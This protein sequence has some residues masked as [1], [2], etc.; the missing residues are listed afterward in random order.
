MSRAVPTRALAAVLVLASL[1]GCMAS[2]TFR[3]AAFVPG[4]RHYRVRY[5]PGEEDLRRVLPGDW[6]IVNYRTDGEGRPTEAFSAPRDLVRVALD[7]NGDRE[8]DV[9]GTTPRFDLHFQH[10]EDGATLS[11]I[12]VPIEPRLSR[13]S[14]AVFAHG[15]VN[16][17]FGEGFVEWDGDRARAYQTRIVEEQEATVGGAPAYL[18]TFEV[19]QVVPGEGPVFGRGETVTIVLVRPG[20][21]GWRGDSVASTGSGV[22]MLLIAMLGA[23]STRYELHRPDFESLLHRLDVRPDG[24]A[25]PPPTGGEEPQQVRAGRGRRRGGPR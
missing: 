22:P 10:D 3:G 6:S 21:L 17:V 1:T 12:T 9:R 7:S 8:V 24:L 16:G 13:R 20:E 15:L 18:L 14:L 23:P 4:P 2:E 11:V 19:A 25:A 5:L